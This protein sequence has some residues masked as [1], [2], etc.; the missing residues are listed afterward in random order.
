MLH[1]GEL[2]V[3]SQERRAVSKT[4]NFSKLDQIVVIMSLMCFYV[5][6]VMGRVGRDR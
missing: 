2:V 1:N 5:L 4:N 6:R 3:C